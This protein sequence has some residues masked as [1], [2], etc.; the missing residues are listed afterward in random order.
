[1]VYPVDT[2]SLKYAFR[3]DNKDKVVANDVNVIYTEVTTIEGQLGVGGVIT[4]EWSTEGTSY[5]TQT[6]IW[7]SLKDRLKNIEEGV[8][9]GLFT[10]VKNTGGSTINSATSSTVGLIIKSATSN[11]VDLFRAVDVND[12]VLARVNKDG[13]FTAVLIDGGGA[14]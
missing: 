1:M 8:V 14:E 7:P 10:S 3:T 6:S 5:S 4:S 13:K 12:N 11:S 2:D 9:K